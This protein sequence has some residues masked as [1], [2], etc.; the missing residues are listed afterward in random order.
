MKIKRVIAWTFAMLLMLSVP[1]CAS[2][3]EIGTEFDYEVNDGKATLIRWKEWK[4]KDILSLII[5]ESIDGYPVVAIGPGVSS[6]SVASLSV[7]ASLERIEGD[8]SKLRFSTVAVK[9]GNRCFSAENNILYDKEKTRLLRCCS[10]SEK[11]VTLPS[12]VRVIEPGAFTFSDLPS[13]TLPEGM[14]EIGERAFEKAYI[15]KI[16]LPQGVKSI[17]FMAFASTLGCSVNL[18]DTVEEIAA[19]AF[20]YGGIPKATIPGN[21]KH[22]APRAFCGSSLQEVTIGEGTESIGTRCFAFCNSL[23]K[24]SLPSTLREIGTEAFI[25]SGALTSIAFPDGLQKVGHRA[26]YQCKELKTVAKIGKSLAEIG[27]GALAG[28]KIKSFSVD[29]DN[30]FF[31]A[32]DGVLYSKDGTVMIQYPA[33][34]EHGASIPE[35][36][37]VIGRDSVVYQQSSAKLPASIREIRD[38]TI[39]NVSRLY[40]AGTPKSWKE[41]VIT[42]NGTSTLWDNANV[43]PLQWPGLYPAEAGS[44]YYA[45][46]YV[47]TIGNCV[48]II[49]YE[50]PG[51]EKVTWTS[52]DPKVATVDQQGNVTAVGYG[53]TMIRATAILDGQKCEKTVPIQS[54]FTDMVNDGHWAYKA[55]DYMGVQ[56]FYTPSPKGYA[57]LDRAITRAEFVSI[58]ARMSGVSVSNKVNTGFS[59]VPKGMWCAGVVKWASDSGIVSGADGKFMP[60]APITREQLC[61]LMVAYAKHAGIRLKMIKKQVVF[62]DGGKIASWAKS[63]VT[64]C[65]RAGLVSGKGK[66]VFDPK[67][68]TTRLEVASLIMNFHKTYM[69]N[70]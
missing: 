10:N 26:F 67:G 37:Q 18:P 29:E 7:S 38:N 66:N 35:G 61:V 28:G 4:S 40:Y 43:T 9:P 64:T 24:V 44:N 42:T 41:I 34:H 69:N 63:A 25:K 58:F 16:V 56:G 8:I 51:G 31:T 46:Y 21:I 14:T 11:P 52:D 27:E 22:I 70:A 6:R 50:L 65:Q 47:L 15:H 3:Y 1:F 59:D 57:F 5:P 36:V 45:G 19:A 17:G 62:T 2:A 60:G 13:V 30:P 23:K 49:L 53:R 20:E 68:T 12:D 48:H 54:I 32:I 55:V 33:R 39:L